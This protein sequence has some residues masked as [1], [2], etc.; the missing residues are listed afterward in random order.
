[1]NKCGSY[2][3]YLKHFRSKSEMCQPCRDAAKVY[4]KEYSKKNY[5]EQKIRKREVDRRRR[6]QKHRNGFEKYT[7]VE[8]IKEYGSICHICNIQINL[9]FPRHASKDN[10]EMG[11]HIDH[12][13]PISKG[14]PDTLEN[15]RP[16]HGICNIKKNNKVSV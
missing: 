13:I 10:W 16:A 12:V 4:M 3:G 2:A 5:E 15:V 9:S 11:L 6:A 14:G 1:M 7:E 8:V